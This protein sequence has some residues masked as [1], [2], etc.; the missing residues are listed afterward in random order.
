[1]RQVFQANDGRRARGVARNNGDPANL[2][3][4]WLD[5]IVDV[6]SRM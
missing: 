3:T 1:V 5:N 4:I 6:L 2:L